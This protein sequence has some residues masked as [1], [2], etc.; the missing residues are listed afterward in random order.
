[1]WSLKAASLQLEWILI[2]LEVTKRNIDL[3]QAKLN[4]EMG[5]RSKMESNLAKGKLW[6]L[7]ERLNLR[8][9]NLAR[10]LYSTHP[11]R[12]GLSLRLWVRRDSSLLL[13]ARRSPRRMRNQDSKRRRHLSLETCSEEILILR[14]SIWRI[15]LSLVAFHK[16]W[17]LETLPNNSW[18]LT[19]VQWSSRLQRSKELQRTLARSSSSTQWSFCT[20][21]SNK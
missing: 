1:M 21:K 11:S 17:E 13:Q 20:T 16:W 12:K 3:L 5:C 4:W 14:M 2:K 19:L 10:Y 9:H 8:F 6:V 7:I 15:P 18:I